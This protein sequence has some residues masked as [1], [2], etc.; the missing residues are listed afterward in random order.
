MEQR[1]TTPVSLAAPTRY[2]ALGLDGWVVALIVLAG[3]A[4]VALLNPYALKLLGKVYVL[5]IIVLGLQLLIAH[6][7]V[8]TLGQA[9]LVA[10]GGYVAGGIT[11]AGGQSLWL[12]LLA[13]VLGTAVLGAAMG[14]VVLR[15]QGLYQL[16][17]TL[18]VGQMV[19]YGLQSLRFLGGDDGFALKSRP[20]LWSGLPLESDR[21]WCLVIVLMAA[22][23]AWLIQRVRQ[24][25][26]GYFM[27][28]ARDDERKLS[29]L[30]MSPGVSKLWAFVIAAVFAGIGGAL[31]AHLTR[32]TS[33]QL[34][35][36]MF[37]G[38]L[39]VLVLLGGGRTR[40]GAFLACCALV[41]VQEV[42]AQYTD[43]WPLVLGVVVLLRVLWPQRGEGQA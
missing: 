4:A 39:M 31:L 20:E 35:S 22:L 12:M 37:S 17:A 27:Q 26:M 7:G 40:F 28:A 2:R 41:A 9:A 3:C 43:H 30:G 34:G 1:L 6:A 42:V 33:P 32:F 36:W 14:A 13:V 10:I 16:M 19:Y 15:T 18:A 11:L 25:E 5:W 8:V 21:A 23:A 29:A 24:S 38:E